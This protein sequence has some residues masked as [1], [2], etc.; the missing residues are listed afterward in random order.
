M[1]GSALRFA[2]VLVFAAF[3]ASLLPAASS[4][5]DKDNEEAAPYEKDEFHPILSDLRRAEII[6]FGSFPFTALFSIVFYEVFRYFYNGMESAYLPWPFKDSSTAI[7]IT[8]DEYAMLLVAS[9]GISVG[10]G[11]ADFV[12]RKALKKRRERRAAEAAAQE[13]HPIQVRPRIYADET[14]AF[15][16]PALPQG[17]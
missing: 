15:P 1:K 16:Q 8:N 17:F 6:A 3:S 10:I 4:S 12:V 14:S 9:A 7:A 11:V 13:V 2:A 5:S